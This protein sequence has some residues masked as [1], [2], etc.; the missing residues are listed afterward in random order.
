M[1]FSG[2]KR[3]RAKMPKGRFVNSRTSRTHHF[4]QTNPSGKLNWPHLPSGR[5]CIVREMDVGLSPSNFV[6][7]EAAVASTDTSGPGLV[8]LWSMPM[9]FRHRWRLADVASATG[10]VPHF[11]Q[12]KNNPP[13][14]AS[15]GFPLGHNDTAN[16]QNQS[17]DC[18]GNKEKKLTAMIL[19][20]DAQE[21]GCPT[22]TTLYRKLPVAPDIRALKITETKKRVKRKQDN[23]SGRSILQ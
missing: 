3:A 5:S 18:F 8:S 4:A 9:R 10:P 23:K 6:K 13:A 20:R 11:P 17:R 2:M 12:R 7:F 21:D 14:A 16:Q 22:G 15:Q 19:T 1:A